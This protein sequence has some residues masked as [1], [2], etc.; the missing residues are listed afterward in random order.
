M[1][2]IFGF[3]HAY[4]DADIVV[5]GAPF[6]STVS[7]RP[8]T[9]FAPNAMRL[10][11]IGLE[12]YSPYLDA[13]L[14]NIRIHD[15]GDLELCFGD[16]NR[17]LCTIESFAAKAINDQKLPVMIGGEHLVSL[18][19]IRAAAK[20]YP[21]LRVLHFDAHTDLR[22]EYLGVCLSHAT[23]MRRV[24]DMLGD[25]R[26]YQ[27]GIRSGDREEFLWSRQHVYM[28]KFDFNGLSDVIQSLTGM[29]V[30]LS[31]DLDVL[32][33]S[34][35]PGTGTPEPGGIS[36]LQLLQA[37]YDCCKLNIVGCDIVELCPIYDQS[38]VSTAVALKILR[39]LLLALGAKK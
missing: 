6:D 9:R 10:D 38:G 5:F 30:Y 34:I 27:F 21:E 23:V 39:E 25:G 37:V 19:T 14:T 28:Q 11:S 29:P 18:G 35:F 24:W 33:P 15:A 7:F 32:D 26:I 4:D 13:D 22:A 8:G 3:E 16:T 36:F 20:R 12:S 17:T 1:T 2:T 31:I